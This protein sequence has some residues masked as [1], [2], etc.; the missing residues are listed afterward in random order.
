MLGAQVSCPV[1]VYGAN[2]DPLILPGAMEKWSGLTRSFSA[3][4]STRAGLATLEHSIH[5]RQR[6]AVG[7]LQARFQT[8]AL[9]GGVI[10]EGAELWDS[11]GQL[12]AMSRQ[13]ALVQPFG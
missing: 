2:A 9:V 10:E 7:W 11:K 12:V 1:A 8:R 5:L 6:P 4:A 13:L 3:S